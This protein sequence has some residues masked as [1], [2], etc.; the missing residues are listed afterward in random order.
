MQ[1]SCL[2]FHH[3][4]QVTKK[5]LVTLIKSALSIFEFYRDPD[6]KMVKIIEEVSIQIVHHFSE[7]EAAFERSRKVFK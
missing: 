2:F 4:L 7:S 6:C 3:Q 1:K 5:I